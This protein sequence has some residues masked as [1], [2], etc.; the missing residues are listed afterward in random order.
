MAPEHVQ[1][2]H[3]CND[4][5][6]VD[7][8]LVILLTVNLLTGRRFAEQDLYVVLARILR[9][10]KLNYPKNAKLEPIYHTLI[11][12]KGPVRVHFEPRLN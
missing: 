6:L 9:R 8:D 1:V 10:F 3:C 5:F 12:P 11:F 7:V 4:C 2:G